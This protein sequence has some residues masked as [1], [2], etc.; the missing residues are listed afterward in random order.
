[1][2]FNTRWEVGGGGGGYKTSYENSDGIES[3]KRQISANHTYRISFIYLTFKMFIDLNGRYFIPH[4]TSFKKMPLF[5][6]GGSGLSNFQKKKYCPRVN[7]RGKCWEPGGK[8]S[9]KY[10]QPS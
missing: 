10:F 2:V 6:D 5:F 3:Q 7:L 4:T 8:K 1:M 9:S